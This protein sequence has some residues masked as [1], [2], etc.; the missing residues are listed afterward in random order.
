LELER[1]YIRLLQRKANREGVRERLVRILAWCHRVAK[2]PE[3]KAMPGFSPKLRRFSEA[4]RKQLMDIE[5]W[6]EAYLDLELK[7]V[8]EKILFFKGLENQAVS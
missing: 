7:Q 6:E 1:D 5:P 3:V 2:L 8:E 4:N